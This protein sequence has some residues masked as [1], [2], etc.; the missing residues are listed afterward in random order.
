MTAR[1]RR[2]EV[3]QEAGTPVGSRMHPAST[4]E[5]LRVGR[6]NSVLGWSLSFLLGVLIIAAGE[7]VARNEWISPLIFPAPSDVAQSLWFGLTEGR[8][9]VHIRSTLTSTVVGFLTAST[10]AIILAGILSSFR[11]IERILIPYVV[12]FQSL[13]KIAVAPLIVIWLGFGDVAKTAIVTIV[14][15]FPVMIS[16]LQG[17][18][19]R[20]REYLE[21]ML[22]LGGSR[23]QLFRYIRLP[24]ALPYVFGGLHIGA[25]FALIGAVVAEFIASTAGLGY[26]L[27][28]A[29]S[30]FN[31]SGVFAILVILM[32]LGM[33][34]HGL[35]RFVEHRV[36]F[37][38][39]D[40]TT[41]S[42]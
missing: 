7:I 33:A 8:Y 14:V 27:I 16:S 18:R 5:R 3:E 19:L 23:W 4:N 2:S 15:F 26:A 11:P 22:I 17:F 1:D 41:I 10:I 35:M 36:A 12:A 25:L 32:A 9:L 30:Q 31:T 39:K 40:V 20:E 6:D 42:V 21:L 24:G 29:Q 37:W 38:A 13:P 34:L 28:I